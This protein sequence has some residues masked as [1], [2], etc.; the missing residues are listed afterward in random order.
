HGQAVVADLHLV[1]V[2]QRRRRR[3]LGAVH[4]HAGEA[5]EVLDVERAVLPDQAGVPPGHVALGQPDRL[6]FETTD[7]D[8]VPR[9]RNDRRLTFIVLD[10]QLEHGRDP[11][12]LRLYPSQ[13]R[14]AI[15]P[16]RSATYATTSAI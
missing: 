5:G 13:P 10:R 16:W 12:D 8:F 15:A 2:A 9:K 1:A 4:A 7:R 6:A 3:D 11:A 14:G